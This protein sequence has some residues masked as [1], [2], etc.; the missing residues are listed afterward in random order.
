MAL[1][2]NTLRKKLND[3]QV[4]AGSVIYSW[5]PEVMDQAGMAGLDYMRIDSEHGWRRDGFMDFVV[6][7]ALAVGVVPI[8][9]VDRDDPYLVRKALEIGAGGV[10]VPDVHTVEDAR[11]VVSASKF[12]PR[13][14][15]GYGAICF[16]G[17]WGTRSGAEWAEWNDTQPLIGVNIENVKAMD[18]IDEILAVEGLDFVLYGP[19][20]FSMS[21]GVGRPLPMTDERIEEPLKR[22]IAAARKSGK[23]V[24]VTAGDRAGMHKYA[25]MGVTMLEVSNDLAVVRAAW[26]E[27]A[28][29]AAVLSAEA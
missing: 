10:I 12:P 16:A 29:T 24:S 19:S 18:H 26:T 9:R 15:R 22:I 25:A 17:G 11:A 8:L 1:E 6:R 3:G 5:S 7:T 20:D 28:R 27:T 2:P 21:L 4:V 13:G 14:I 23:H